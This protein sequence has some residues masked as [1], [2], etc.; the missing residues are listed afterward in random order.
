MRVPLLLLA[1][2]LVL[3]V[4]GCGDDGVTLPGG[5]GAGGFMEA[6]GGGQAA[7]AGGEGGEGGQ[8][9]CDT[10][11]CGDDQFC[12]AG[13]CR[14]CAVETGTLHDRTLA[15]GDGE[16]D[17]FYMLHVPASYSCASPAPLLVDFH[18]TAAGPGQPEEAYQLD[19]L[20][21]LAE[22]KGAVVVR[23]R[24]RSS[25]RGGAQIFRWDQNPGDLERNVTFTQNL[26]QELRSRYRIDEQRIYAS[27]FSSGSNM[28]SQFLGAA[29]GL[30]AGLAPIA[31]GIW[32][33]PG[34]AAF[35]VGSA[36]RIYAATG[37]RDYLHGT[38]QDLLALLAERGVPAE[39]IVQR[40][41]DTGHDLYA[42]H[43]EELWTFL[44]E[45]VRPGGGAL[46]KPWIS[47]TL[48]Q[49]G[50]VLT[51]TPRADG[52]LVATG[53]EGEVWLRS[54][55]GVWTLAQTLGSGPLTGACADGEGNVFVVGE[56]DFFAGSAA[57]TFQSA[58][59]IPEFFGTYFGTSYLNGIGCAGSAPLAAAGYWTGARSS[60]GG[61]SWQGLGVDAGGYPAQ[62][63]AVH[64]SDSGTILAVGYYDYI[65]RGAVGAAGL[66]PVDHPAG[67]EWLTDASSA[68]GGK[69]WVVGDHGVIL[70]SSDDGV[71]WQLQPSGS[72]EDLYA[73][74]V[75]ADGQRA[76]AVGRRGTILVTLD[77]GANWEDWGAGLDVF[78][79]AAAIVGDTLFVAGE[80]G[81]V[82][83]AELLD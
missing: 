76:V 75:A 41:Y 4:F 59:T 22:D 13:V 8:P 50:S 70:A 24:S 79:G 83:R 28:T 23:P 47:E 10:L 34:I 81:L 42:W 26:V 77:G 61:E 2:V 43:F 45:G 40:E 19:A 21:A 62:S 1:S 53:A 27:G 37:F 46:A 25:A 49:A 15:L 55:A 36:P 30:F 14:D 38:R 71:T 29:R 35:E 31:G 39:N 51:L 7:G 69:H 5:G 67:A 32:S 11:V 74:A 63:S 33:D 64:V 65:G 60:D 9:T 48:P 54:A 68:P 6:G 17:R 57:L 73:V 78:F 66:T 56:R 16:E 44:D 52:S 72:D 12:Y 82:L 3:P 20:L 18:G 58:S 80:G